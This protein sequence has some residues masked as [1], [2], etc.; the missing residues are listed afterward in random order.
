MTSEEESAN[1]ESPGSQGEG[2]FMEESIF[3]LSSE[4][5]RWL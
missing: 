3:E 5:G 4:Y 1:E 2:D